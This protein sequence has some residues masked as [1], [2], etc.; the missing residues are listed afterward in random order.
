MYLAICKHTPLHSQPLS[1]FIARTGCTGRKRDRNNKYVCT[2]PVII[3][4]ASTSS[5]PDPVLGALSSAFHTLTVLSKQRS[6]PSSLLHFAMVGIAAIYAFAWKLRGVENISKDE[7]VHLVPSA[8]LLSV[9][10]VS[11]MRAVHTSKGDFK[12][13]ITALLCCCFNG[14]LPKPRVVISTLPFILGKLNSQSVV[15]LLWSPS[16][17]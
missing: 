17:M 6:S 2:S 5:K 8:A 7:L 15:E 4:Q 12:R 1:K 16:S 11:A 14:S 10:Q 13:P 3:A 9:A